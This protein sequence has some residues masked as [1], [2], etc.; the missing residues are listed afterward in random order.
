MRMTATVKTKIAVGLVFVSQV[1]GPLAAQDAYD[2]SPENLA[3]RAWFQDAKFGLFVHWG[4]YSVLGAGEWVMQVRGIPADAYEGV[5]AGFNPVR[6]TPPNG[7][8]S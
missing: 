8:R 6:S 2:P 3:A 7:Y 4:I 1:G 5:A